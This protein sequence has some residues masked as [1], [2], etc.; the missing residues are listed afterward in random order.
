MDDDPTGTGYALGLADSSYTWY[1]GAAVKARRFHRL[2]EVLQLLA[3]AAI[4]LSAAI[5]SDN[6]VIPAVLGAFVVVVTGLRSAFHWQDDYLRFSQAREAV[7][8]ERRLYRTSAAPYDEPGTRDQRLAQSVTRIEQGEMG[9]WLDIA[10][11]RRR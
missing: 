3:S 11:P 5:V 10:A 8:A 4:P 9:G 6:I 2:T 7:E 1:A